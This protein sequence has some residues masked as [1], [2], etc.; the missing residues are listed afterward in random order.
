LREARQRST[1]AAVYACAGRHIKQPD[2]H[3]LNISKGHSRT[4]GKLAKAL[5]SAWWPP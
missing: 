5:S 4:F 2:K 3:A 1:L